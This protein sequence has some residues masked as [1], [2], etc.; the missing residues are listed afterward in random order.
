[1]YFVSSGLDEDRLHKFIG[2]RRSG[3]IRQKL[4][5]NWIGIYGAR[6]ISEITIKI[7]VKLETWN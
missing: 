5:R 2:I 3:G 4:G 1:M 7:N 6:K